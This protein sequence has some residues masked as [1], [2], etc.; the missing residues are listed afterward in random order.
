MALRLPVKFD[1]I[2]LPNQSIDMKKWCV[3][4]CDQYTSQPEYW[5]E[6]K[7][8]VGKDQSASNLIYPE[9]YLNDKP[10]K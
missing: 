9:C 10:E 3:V 4:A 2:L 7:K 1:Q 6:L 5:E 8:F